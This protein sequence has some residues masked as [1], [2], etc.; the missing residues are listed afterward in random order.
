MNFKEIRVWVD[1]LLTFLLAEN[2]T[3]C[4]SAITDSDE[5]T[6]YYYFLDLLDHSCLGYVIHKILNHTNLILILKMNSPIDFIAICRHIYLY[7]FAGEHCLKQ[8]KKGSSGFATNINK[9]FVKNIRYI[10]L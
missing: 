2:I 8:C 9:C 4:E 5:F 10:M 6:K 3:Y 1:I 7:K